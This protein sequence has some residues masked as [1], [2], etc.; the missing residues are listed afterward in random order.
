MHGTMHEWRQDMYVM[1]VC[2]SRDPYLYV[3]ANM[4]Q[5]TINYLIL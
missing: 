5:L 2:A 1:Q 4:T 3:D